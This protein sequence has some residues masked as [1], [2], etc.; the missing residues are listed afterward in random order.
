MKT[1]KQEE[2]SADRNENIGHMHVNIDEFIE[3]YYNRQRLHSAFGYRASEEF[4]RQGECRSPA[5][6]SRG[7][8]VQFF[9][10]VENEMRVSTEL[11]TVIRDQ[12]VRLGAAC[13]RQRERG[14]AGRHR[15]T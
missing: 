10:N 1:L 2:I 4:E 12:I 15:V 8:T 3:Q 7:A 11:E 6:D 14:F 13:N 5:A 9:E